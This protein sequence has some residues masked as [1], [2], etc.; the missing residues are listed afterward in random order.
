MSGVT[1]GLKGVMSSGKGFREFLLKGKIVELAVAVVVGLA[2]SNL[3]TA[4]VKA[5]ITPLIAAIFRGVSF[6]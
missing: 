5:L 2:F 6:S 3:V 4:M 1:A